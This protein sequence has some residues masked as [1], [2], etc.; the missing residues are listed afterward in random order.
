MGSHVVGYP[1][2]DTDIEWLCPYCDMD[3]KRPQ[4]IVLEKPPYELGYTIKSPGILP[5]DFSGYS[6]LKPKK[7]MLDVSCQVCGYVGPSKECLSGPT[8]TWIIFNNNPI[9]FC[10]NCGIMQCVT[11]TE[12]P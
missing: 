12:V 2:G 5:M 6:I 11:K 10:P 9:G 7:Y 4:R 1:D 8:E 3:E